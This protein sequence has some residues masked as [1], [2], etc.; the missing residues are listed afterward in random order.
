M[1]IR[2]FTAA[3]A[4]PNA[5]HRVLITMYCTISSIP[6]VYCDNC[7]PPCDPRSVF[8]DPEHRSSALSQQASML[9]VALYFN[10][11]VLNEHKSLMREVVDKHFNDN[12]VV[13]IYMGI[14]ADLSEEWLPYKAAREAL[15]MDCLQVL[16]SVVFSLCDV[17]S[18][19]VPQCLAACIQLVICCCCCRCCTPT[20]IGCLNYI[21][22]E[23]AFACLCFSV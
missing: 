11:A 10:P 1:C 15:A 17:I 19:H 22:S 18:S 8:P 16:L 9:Y 2:L 13:P 3:T 23:A 5:L 7:V 6:S 21:D 14:L 20:C 4:A 12:W